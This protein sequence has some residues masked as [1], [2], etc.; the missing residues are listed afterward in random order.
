MMEDNKLQMML[1]LL[2]QGP[3][4]E[5]QSKAFYM[6]PW[7]KFSDTH[8]FRSHDYEK[9]TLLKESIERIQGNSSSW[10]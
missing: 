1:G 8:E 4:F 5:D 6:T 2:I 7:S 3:H 9:K 10:F